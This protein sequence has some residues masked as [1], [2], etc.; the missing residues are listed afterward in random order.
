MNIKNF[1]LAYKKNF[2]VFNKGDIH[3]KIVVSHRFAKKKKKCIIYIVQLYEGILCGFLSIT[4]I[5]I[6]TKIFHYRRK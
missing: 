3:F 1:I 2:V 4:G 6:I 5:K